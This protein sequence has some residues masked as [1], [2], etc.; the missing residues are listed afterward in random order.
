MKADFDFR[1]QLVSMIRNRAAIL[2][3][4]SQLIAEDNTASI[5]I[6]AKARTITR[7][8]EE[9]VA[10][11]ESLLRPDSERELSSHQGGTHSE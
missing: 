2:S 3:G 10:D 7:V 8:A 1:R 6:R 11:V 4:T 5:G 9:L